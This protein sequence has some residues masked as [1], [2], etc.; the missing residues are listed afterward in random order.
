MTRDREIPDGWPPSKSSRPSQFK[1]GPGSRSASAASR[2]L[3]RPTS[4][5][6]S[7]RQA[8]QELPTS[9][10]EPPPPPSK[11][12][13]EPK[14]R[15]RVT[16]QFWAILVVLISSGVGITAV[17]LLLKLPAVP[18]CPATFWPTA[19]ASMRL[20]CAQLA[21][22]KQTADNL[23]EAI[24]L[25]DSLPK[26]HPLRLEIN[27]QIEEW[28]L[29]IL[30]IGEG[31]FQGG[32]LTEAI[33]IAKRIP[34]GTPAYK[35]VE[36]HIANWQKIWA[37]AQGIFEKTE[38][39]LRQ[40]N[41]NMAFAEAVKLTSVENKYWATT[42]Y[43]QL[44]GLVRIAR[45]ASAQLDK[46]RDLS[47]SDKVDDIL[48]AIKQAEKI[49]S[50]SYIYKS[51]QKLIADS[52]KKLVKMAEYQLEEGNGKAVTEIAE[53]I[54]ASVKLAEVKSDLIE[55]G[56]ALTYAKSGSVSDLENA[57]A[58]SKKIAQ[59][60]PLY[61]KAQKFASTWQR[62]I[63]DVTRLERARTLASS[64]L[65]VDLRT[66]IVEAEKIPRGNPRYS[67]AREEMKRWKSQAETIE[68]QPYLD[69]A[70]QIA[71]FGNP[72][73]LQEAIQEASRIAPGR[74]LHS[75]AQ[76]K[77]SQ[78]T[79]AIQRQ[80]DQP[81]L[82]Q[83]RSLAAGGNLTSAITAAQQIKSGRSLH[84]EAQSDIRSWQTEIEG[85]QRLEEAYRTANAGTADSFANAIRVARQ[86]PTSSKARSDARTVVNRWS[87]QIL[88]MAQDRS[89]FNVTEAIAIA[90]MVPSGTEAYDSAQDQIRSWQK[91]LEPAPAPAPAPI[92]A[93]VT[94]PEPAPL[95]LP[96]GT[97]GQ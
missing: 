4:G 51:A 27:R 67:E 68:D 95:K 75:K 81:Y 29:D 33:K 70:S 89:S 34:D 40:T 7:R 39:E 25:V 48:A 73:S 23:L 91:M 36:E 52:G 47:Q 61:A 92:P 42:K 43:D 24:A 35:L 45:E 62:E 94:A 19:S 77:I 84:S 58:S 41:W 18:N 97:D 83:A 71:N 21:A 31:K 26:D 49:P 57:I 78:W 37:K 88:S 32:N 46:A 96:S 90:K 86:V 17:A 14:R 8:P 30:K 15:F 16:W 79:G 64:G 12:R 6:P 38:E 13:R 80:Q 66:A 50:N 69:R 65:T 5:A 2:P 59:G 87:Y 74:A 28:S 55:I 93:P 9:P 11:L 44:T 72:V 10:P 63:E 3:V 20:Y 56:R 85:Q 1:G 54:P 76:E 53:K 82:D 22:N 60:R